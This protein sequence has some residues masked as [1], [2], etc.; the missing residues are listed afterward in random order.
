VSKKLF[1]PEEVASRLD[2]PPNT[3]RFWCAFFSARLSD[4]ATAG[5][6][7]ASETSGWVFTEKDVI[8]L[9]K[10]RLLL[11]RAVSSTPE[12]DRLAR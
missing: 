10:V 11:D 12:R 6:C 5:T 1:S 7:V 2:I 4:G 8:V 3:L 9:S